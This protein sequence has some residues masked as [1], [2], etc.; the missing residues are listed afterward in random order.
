MQSRVNPEGAS[1]LICLV[2]AVAFGVEAFRLGLGTSGSP[3]PGLTPFLYASIL[4][5]LSACLLVRSRPVTARF[6]IVLQWRSVVPILAVLLAY[7]VAIEWLGY[8]ACTFVALFALLQLAGARR[9]QSLVLSAVA[10]AVVHLV[11]VKWL[12]VPLPIG[13]IFP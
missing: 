9:V 10:T 13:S 1:A 6:E 3:G 5:I 2:V 4:A 11:F 8:V 12:L 7:A